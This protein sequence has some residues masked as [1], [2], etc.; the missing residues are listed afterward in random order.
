MS[1]LAAFVVT[2]LDCLLPGDGRWPAAGATNAPRELMARIRQD[3]ALAATV[4]RARAA[5]PAGFTGHDRAAQVYALQRFEQ[6]EPAS[7]AAI[8]TEAFA[9][10]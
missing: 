9:A 4:E 5:L 10:Y 1:D 6:D 7:F 8:L 2:L 3:A